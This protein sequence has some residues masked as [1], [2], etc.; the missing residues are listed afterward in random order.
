MHMT[1]AEI[2]PVLQL[3]SSLLIAPLCQ[4]VWQMNARIANIEGK[5]HAKSEG[6]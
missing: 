4:A 5:L 2:L 1:F 3:I 6:K